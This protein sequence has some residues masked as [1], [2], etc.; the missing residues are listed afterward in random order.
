MWVVNNSGKEIKVE[1][2]THCFIFYNHFK[3]EFHFLLE[4]G[5]IKRIGFDHY[6]WTKSKTS[7]AEYFRWL[8]RKFPVEG[9]YWAPIAKAFI[10]KGKAITTRQLSKLASGN[11]NAAKPKESKDFKII[12]KIV[13]EYREAV[14]LQEEQDQKDMRAFYDIKKLVDKVEIRDI[15][16]IR[17]VL[18]KGNL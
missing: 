6:E 5:I 2:I 16:K 18:T 9:G 7:L 11:G 8:D 15:K 14:K 12:K 1:E 17:T 3:K 4:L 13:E 10:V